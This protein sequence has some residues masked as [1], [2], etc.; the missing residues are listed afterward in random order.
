MRVVVAAIDAARKASANGDKQKELTERLERLTEATSAE[1]VAQQDARQLLYEAALE[2][3]RDAFQRLKRVDLAELTAIGTRLLDDGWAGGP[4]PRMRPD[5]NMALGSVGA[6]AGGALVGA[7]AGTAAYLAVGAFATA[8]TGAAISGLSGAAATSAT[9]AWLGGG[10]IAAGG[11]GVAAGVTALTWIVAAPV[12]LAM[13][14]F[15]EWWGRGRRAEQ[16]R[17]ALRLA[18]AE[19]A[20]A[21]AEE[22]AA[23]FLPH[24][25]V[26]RARL[27]ALRRALEERLPRFEALVAENGG[28]ETYSVRQREQVAVLAGLATT[29]VA[30]MATPLADADGRPA[31][32]SREAVRTVEERLAAL[33]TG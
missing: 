25:V 17:A 24:S 7:G 22:S 26:V 14:G 15:A 21:A 30:F 20:L 29:A 12:A 8:S 9:L 33:A 3:F 13:L 5:G 2:P 10:S 18:E 16:E 27:W 1:A 31:E 11:G 28:Y 4:V 23:E 6:L 32:A 19:A